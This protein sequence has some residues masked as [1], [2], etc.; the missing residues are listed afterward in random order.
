MVSAKACYQK[1]TK[2]KAKGEPVGREQMPAP[3]ETNT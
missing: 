1:L 2:G 3:S